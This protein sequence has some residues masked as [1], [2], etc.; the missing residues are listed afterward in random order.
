MYKNV[1]VGG[2]PPA[3]GCKAGMHLSPSP[4]RNLPVINGRSLHETDRNCH[5]IQYTIYGISYATI[6][7]TMSQHYIVCFRRCEPT[8]S[9]PYVRY[10][11]IP[12]LHYT[13]YATSSKNVRYHMRSRMSNGKNLYKTYNI[14]RFLAISYVVHTMS[15]KKCTTSYYSYTTSYTTSYVKMA[16]TCILTSHTPYLNS[17]KLYLNIV[18]KRLLFWIHLNF[19]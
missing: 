17:S 16:R 15:Y 6:L 10:R 9:E 18:E 3:T 13:S 19:V 5:A 4:L 2:R 7:H 11:I 8:I 1:G 12:M 14:V